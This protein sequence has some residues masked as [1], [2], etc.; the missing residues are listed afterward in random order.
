M[1]TMLTMLIMLKV[2]IIFKNNVNKLLT[3]LVMLQ[4]I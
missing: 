3:I 1:F 2:I 4:T